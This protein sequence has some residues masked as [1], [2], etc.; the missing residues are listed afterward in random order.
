MTTR[1]EVR[2]AF[3]RA[4]E[5]RCYCSK[6]LPTIAWKHAIEQTTNKDYSVAAVSK[7][8]NGIRE[9]EQSK[10][11]TD[12]GQEHF[13][14]YAKKAVNVGDSKTSMVH[15][16]YVK[17]AN[18]KSEPPTSKDFKFWQRLYDKNAACFK[19][20]NAGQKRKR[21][22]NQ[23]LSVNKVAESLER[24]DKSRQEKENR[25]QD[26][27][28]QPLTHSEK[29][30]IL[31][32]G[33]QLV[34]PDD[35]FPEELL[36]QDNDADTRKVKNKCGRYNVEDIALP[37]GHTVKDVPKNYRL[38]FSGKAGHQN[39]SVALVNA[40]KAFFSRKQVAATVQTST[41]HASFAAAYPT[42][43]DFQSITAATWWASMVHLNHRYTMPTSTSAAGY[44]SCT[45][46]QGMSSDRSET[47]N[48]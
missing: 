7:V 16:Y 46:G 47:R 10:F 24:I 42:V 41:Y 26:D 8:I 44:N 17:P 2:N 28:K 13:V 1:G 36:V 37:N 14:N 27:A 22:E 45:T 30:A 15:F 43:V 5:R 18:D 25:P 4:V 21:P 29:I 39:K 11:V 19:P 35:P 6:W 38:V 3:L 32:E 34:R 48:S 33:W 12:D 40:L 23:P 31:R 20:R 9:N